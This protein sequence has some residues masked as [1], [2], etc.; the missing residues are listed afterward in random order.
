[1]Q[2]CN[3]FFAAVSI[4]VV[5]IGASPL[6]ADQTVPENASI[7]HLENS[8]KIVAT[9]SDQDAYY[10]AIDRGDGQWRFVNSTS[11]LLRLNFDQFDPLDRVPAVPDSLCIKPAKPGDDAVGDGVYIVQFVTQPL[12][13]YRRDIR[14][15]GGTI[16]KYLANHAYLVRLDAGARVAVQAL[17]YVRWVGDYQPAYKLDGLMLAAVQNGSP[18]LLPTRVNIMV[19]ERGIAQKTKV[20]HRIAALGGQ[21][22]SIMPNGFRIEATLNGAQLVD[23][24]SMPEVLWIDLWSAREV[25]TDIAR[26]IG[27]INHIEK[28]AGYSGQ[29]VRGELFDTNLFDS[30][31]DFQAI[32][33]VFHGQRSGSDD[34]GSGTYGIV[35]GDGTGDP[36]ARGMIPAA[37]GIFADF[38]FLSDRYQ[39]TSELVQS[40]YFAVF[41]SNS[42]GNSVTT[43]YTSISAEMDDIIFVNDL[44]ITQ[45][46][47]NQNGQLSRPQAWAKNVV[48]IGGVN[49]QNTL[50]KSDDFWGGASIGPAQDG[51]IK[52][53]LVHF[54]DLIWT[55][56]D[57]QNGYRN[58][59]CTSGATPLVAGHFG[60][61]F[62]MWSDGIFGNDVDANGTVFDNRSHAS[63]A[64]A[65]LINH[66]S[67]YPFSGSNHNLTRT[68][69]GWGIPDVGRIYDM[70]SSTFVVDEDVVLENLG[71]VTFELAV[72]DQM[73]EFRATMV[74]TDVMGTT[75]SNQHRINDLSL[76]V[77]SP[78]GTV[79]WGNNGLLTGNWSTSGGSDNTI[80]TVENVFVQNPESGTWA[81]EV[82]A[83]EINEDAHVETGAVDADFAL[84]VS[85]VSASRV[86]IDGFNVLRGV[87][88]AGD[89]EDVFESDDSYLKFKP[90]LTLNSSEPPVWIEFMGTL[91]GD[92]PA[93][94]TITLE[95][96]ANTLGLNQTMEMFNYNSGLYELVKMQSASFNVDSISTVDVS[97]NIPD[98]VQAGTGSV[99]ARVGWRAAG[100][101]LIYPWTICIDQIDWSVGK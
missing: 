5:S 39:H 8:T 35:F 70:R 98:Y 94:L 13:E 50:S 57:T 93:A 33:P 49:H 26:E 19:F 56:D 23:I 100:P 101:I 10:Y 46:Q 99:Q 65:M 44:L 55:T 81:V 37:Q 80:D 77:T 52:P 73:P 62:Q 29:G 2:K 47:S 4:I 60:L 6:R 31:V 54:Y 17:P 59:C 14:A 95:A 28:V 78:G 18:Q 83:S 74:Y 16:Y 82:I 75:S 87:Q 20:A 45:S 48:S 42:W 69:Q 53:D 79:Y 21:V 36:T 12:E 32:P 85:G 9:W 51:R 58:F 40:P 68:H 41:Q 92:N 15:L 30:H 24:A 66:A 89:L 11:Y 63:T 64:K 72:P 91:P 88:T 25:D 34:H 71:S 22:N 97:A 67:S 86:V 61:F 76:K 1:M 27:G 38:D 84:V 96:R 90:G 7:I 43:Q 3:R